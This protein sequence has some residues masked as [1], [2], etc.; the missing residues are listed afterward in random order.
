V[1]KNLTINMQRHTLQLQCT[2]KGVYT[3]TPR[4][5]RPPHGN[6]V[7]RLLLLLLL[8]WWLLEEHQYGRDRRAPQLLRITT[9]VTVAVAAVAVVVLVVVVYLSVCARSLPVHCVARDGWRRTR[10]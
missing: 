6:N 10:T 1:H 9:P 7:L 8:L 4:R 2:T 5:R 3:R